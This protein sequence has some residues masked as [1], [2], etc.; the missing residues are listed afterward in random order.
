[1]TT[2]LPTVGPLDIVLIGVCAF[3]QVML[4]RLT[5]GTPPLLVGI[6]VGAITGAA[7]TIGRM[8][9]HRQGSR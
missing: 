5:T 2:K 4:I 6:I 7:W 9:A 1:M 3:V 8:A